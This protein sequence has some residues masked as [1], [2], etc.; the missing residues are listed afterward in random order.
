MPISWKYSTGVRP[1]S[2]DS[3]NHLVVRGSSE[4]WMWKRVPCSRAQAFWGT[5]TARLL[6]RPRHEAGA[7]ARGLDRLG[8]LEPGDCVP[9]LVQELLGVEAVLAAHGDD[10]GGAGGLVGLGDVLQVVL[11]PVAVVHHGRRDPVVDVAQARHAVGGGLGR[12]AQALAQFVLAGVEE[13]RE[14]VD[15]VV[16]PGG[17]RLVPGDADQGLLVVVAVGLH[18]GR[19][20]EHVLHGDGVRAGDLPAGAEDLQGGAPGLQEPLPG[21]RR[22]GPGLENASISGQDVAVVQAKGAVRTGQGQDVP[23]AAKEQALF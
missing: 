6:V 4:L 23:G 17:E 16:E 14:G 12:A 1:G 15:G 9:G 11:V 22:V 8:L 10:H 2:M 19:Q 7:L 20:Q 13:A 18:E 5:R 3:V 21:F